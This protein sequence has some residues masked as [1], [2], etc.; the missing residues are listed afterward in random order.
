MKIKIFYHVVDL[1]GWQDITNE[2]LEK[3]QSSGL[4]DQCEL[5]MNLN[6]NEDSFNLLKAQLSN[7]NNIVWHFKNNL[8]EDYEHP[9][10][11][12]MKEYADSS[13]DEFYALY[14]HQKG[15]TYIGTSYETNVK[16]WRWLL[17]YWCI[18]RWEDCI[19]KLNQGYDTTGINYMER[20]KGLGPHFSGTQSWVTSKFLQKCSPLVLPSTIGFAPQ[21]ARKM[22]GN[23]WRY[24]VEAWF[25]NNGASAACL[26]HS[27]LR[28]HYHQEWPPE[29]YRGITAL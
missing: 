19:E 23:V 1:P 3:L 6:Y 5:H 29:L 14:M 25:G 2:Q 9:T 26:Y 24:D 13:Q 15:I 4:L 12:L 28:D 27:G 7:K 21:V 22:K 11:I 8:K 16:H 18:E 17:D 20:H 10:A